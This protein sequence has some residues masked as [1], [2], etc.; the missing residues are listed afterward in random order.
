MSGLG[1]NI[2]INPPVPFPAS[3][4]ASAVYNSGVFAS[5]G[6]AISFGYLAAGNTS[7]SFQRYLDGA[8]KLPVGSAVT[9]TGT[10]GTATVDKV[11]DGVAWL[12]GVL[13]ITDTSGAANAI[14]ASAI[15]V[16]QGG[17]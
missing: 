4:A 14:T 15:V 11:N 16:C 8:K 6:P 1:T 5:P 17:H 2:Q 9:G 7:Y 10:G 12:Y 13:T 3:L